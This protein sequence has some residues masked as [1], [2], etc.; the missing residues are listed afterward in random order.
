MR[1]DKSIPQLR[2]LQVNVARSP[3]PHEAALQLAFEQDYH[4]VLVQ[5]PWISSFHTRRLSK[6]SP[7][8]Q[9]F[10]PIENWTCRPRT[11]T[12]IRKHP[13]LE[14][15]LVPHGPQP[16]RDLTAVHVSSGNQHVTLLN[17]YNAPPG[18]VD[19][20]EGLRHLQSQP[21]PP[22]SCLIAGDF[23]LHHQLWQ[24]NI[25]TS[26]GAEPFLQWAECQGLTLNLQPNTPTRAENTICDGLVT[27]AGCHVRC[28]CLLPC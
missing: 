1:Y 28:S 26:T 16:N 27:L 10:T 19:A 14:A 5:E 15:E 21:L 23:N 11:L 24:T 4:V 20:G 13:Q 7:A 17:L 2:I 6:H 18:S 9:L 25:I 22:R 8:F 3:S 12:Y